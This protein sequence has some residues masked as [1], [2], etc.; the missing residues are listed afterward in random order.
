MPRRTTSDKVLRDRALNIDKNPKHDGYQCGL[1]S[2]FYKTYE[3]KSSVGTITRANKS[4][5]ISK[6]QLTE[7]SHEMY[8]H[9]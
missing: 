2:I 9:L 3:K 5:I 8:T 4:A 7:E 6:Q 1:A